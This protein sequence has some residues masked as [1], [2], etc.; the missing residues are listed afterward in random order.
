M[1]VRMTH[2]CTHDGKTYE[3]GD[4]V[5]NA[6]LEKVFLAEGVAETLE[7]KQDDK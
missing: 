3:V 2:H 4:Q 5:K 7:D 1:A 6:K